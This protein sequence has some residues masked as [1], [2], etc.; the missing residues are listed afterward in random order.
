MVHY[1]PLQYLLTA[2]E[3]PETDRDPVD[4]QLQILKQNEYAGM[5]CNRVSQSGYLKLA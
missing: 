2:E 5:C 1:N 4:S 3:L